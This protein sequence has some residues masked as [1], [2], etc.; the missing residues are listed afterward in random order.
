MGAE[1]SIPQNPRVT[2]LMSVYNGERYISEAVDSILGQTLTDFEFLIIDDAST[3]RTPEILR[4]Y[5]DPRIRVVTNEENLGLTKSLNKGLTLARGEYIARMDADDVSYPYRLQVQHEFMTQHP[6]AGIIGSWAEY[7]DRKGEIVH[8]YEAPGSPEENYFYLHFRNCIVHSSVMFRKDVIIPNSGYDESIDKAQDFELWNRLSKITD[9]YQI[10]EFLVQWRTENSVDPKK[11]EAQ[12]KTWEQILR[13]EYW[14]LTQMNIDE[15]ILETIMFPPHPTDV[16]SLRRYSF[17]EYIK[18]IK[19]LRLFHHQIIKNA[20]V[21]LNRKP[22]ENLCKKQLSYYI[23]LIGVR[24][25]IS[26][27]FKILTSNQYLDNWYEKINVIIKIAYFKLRNFIDAFT[28][29]PI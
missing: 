19:A 25:N 13:K 20:P 11:I 6:R 9:I 16:Q 26:K 23:V 4:S 2:V 15:S 7:I 10:P 14:R 27:D 18:S 21:T 8:R 3:D 5:D 12:N 28:G 1:H 24:G 17:Q 29:S 22:L